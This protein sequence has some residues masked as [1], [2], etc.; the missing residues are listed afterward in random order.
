M[1]DWK[2]KFIEFALSRQL[3]KFGHFTL[4]SGRKSPYFFNTGLLSNGSDI[5]KLGYFYATLLINSK[6]EFDV[7]FGLA[8][9]GIPI[10]ISTAIALAKYYK[11]KTPYCFN[12]KEVKDHG[13]GGLLIGNPLYGKIILVDDVITTGKSISE[14]V[15]IMNIYNANL[16]GILISLDRQETKF[17]N[18]IA[19]GHQH[20]VLSI[21]TLS[22][23]V[24]YLKTKQNMS[25]NLK[26]IYSY[27]DT[28]GI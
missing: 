5:A 8:Y 11:I 14:S 28:Y 10:V 20:T 17:N 24:D 6:I 2:Y 23:L 9:K 15:N 1:E 21:I 12:R 4:K 18:A 22:D 19:T 26:F 27:Q 16:I 13:E 7:L 25:N 3:I